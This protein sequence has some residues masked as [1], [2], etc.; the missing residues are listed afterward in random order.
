M[1]KDHP[2]KPIMISDFGKTEGH[3][4]PKWLENTFSYIKKQPGIG[5][6][7]Y[8][9]NILNIQPVEK[10]RDDHTLSDESLY[11][12]DKILEDP[13]FICGDKRRKLC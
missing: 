13:Y 11:V 9:D 8:W 1:R 4:Q 10:N 3:S 7:G 2:D 5:G 12:L 6:A